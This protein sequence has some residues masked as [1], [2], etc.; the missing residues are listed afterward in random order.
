[1]GNPSSR[2]DGLA[3]LTRPMTLR[4]SEISDH[5]QLPIR[6]DGGEAVAFRERKRQV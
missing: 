5:T 1:M 4:G 6:D 3:G 2:T